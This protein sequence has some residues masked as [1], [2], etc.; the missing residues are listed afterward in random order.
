[1]KDLN[2]NSI[3]KLSPVPLYFQLKEIII[4]NI[5]NH[6]YQPNE[7]IPTEKELM[8]TFD[9]SRTTVRQA[10]DILVNEGQLERRRGVGTFVATPDQKLSNLELTELNSYIDA[11]EKQGLKG[12]TEVI[13]K[14][15]VPTTPLLE[16]IFGDNYQQFYRLERLRYIADSP[17]LLVTTYVPYEIFPDL[18]NFDFTAVSLFDTLKKY[19]QVKIKYAEKTFNATNVKKHDAQTLGI[20]EHNAIQL[21]KTITYDDQDLPI[22]YS[23]SRDR[24]DMS[25]FNITL[26]YNN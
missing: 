8:T 26:S 2:P 12:R 25:R 13:E 7:K 23:L 4:E 6:L 5:E 16:S 17:S 24:G 15:V 3:N 10:I 21:V 1:M 20:S 19:Y 11:L 18:L 9:V 22:E 14:I